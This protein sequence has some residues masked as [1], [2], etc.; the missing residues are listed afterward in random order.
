MQRRAVLKA[1]GLVSGGGDA[2]DD[3]DEAD[4]KELVGSN[5]ELFY[6]ID[7]LLNSIMETHGEAA[8]QPYENIL[9]EM[10]VNM[11]HKHCLREDREF[12]I[13]VISDLIRLSVRS[14]GTAQ[15]YYPEILPI[16]INDV[17]SNTNSD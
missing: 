12:A 9:R 5:N 2:F 13:T 7:N 17:G 6:N 1:E 16:L 15:R 11:A 8:I 4:E 10:V 3:E 14:E